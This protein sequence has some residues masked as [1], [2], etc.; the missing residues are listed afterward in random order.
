M[1]NLEQKTSDTQTPLW[2]KL[3]GIL[4]LLL[5]LTGFIYLGWMAIHQDAAA[6]D[7][8]FNITRISQISDGF[9]VEVEVINKSSQSLAALYLEGRLITGDGEPEINHAQVD[10]LP[11]RSK[12]HTGFFFSRDPRAG[13]LEFK[14]SGYQEP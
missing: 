6:P 14:P 10:Y 8:S 4:G 5:V 3:L 11:S 13:T 9:L 12:G 1:K 7:V 2:E